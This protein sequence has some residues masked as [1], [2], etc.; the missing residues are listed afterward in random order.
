MHRLPAGLYPSREAIGWAWAALAAV[1]SPDSEALASLDLVLRETVPDCEAEGNSRVLPAGWGTPPATRRP[2]VAHPRAF[3]GTK[4]RPPKQ[5]QSAAVD[6][7]PFLSSAAGLRSVAERF[8]R[9]LDIAVAAQS[10]KLPPK[11]A[12]LLWP[13]VRHRT[14]RQ[15]SRLLSLYVA[16]GL[17]S[18]EELLHALAYS[19]AA[20]P[21]NAISWS[22]AL[23]EVPAPFRLDMAHAIIETSAFDVEAGAAGLAEVCRLAP[24]ERLRI[25]A[26]H[27]LSVVRDRGDS[28]YLLA[29]FRLAAAFDPDCRFDDAGR[30]AD[31]PESEIEAIGASLP[32]SHRGWLP[33]RLWQHCGCFPGM[34]DL[35]RNSSWPKLDRSAST[36]YLR[37]L[38]TVGP[39]EMTPRTA[40]RK[41]TALRNA[42]PRI[43]RILLT[44]DP[45]Y[46]RKAVA[47]AGDWL[48][49]WEDP[50]AIQRRL[51]A[52]LRLLE[53]LA[54]PP[55]SAAA[56][57]SWTLGGF[58]EFEN[59]GHIETFLQAPDSCLLAVERASRRDN[60]ARLIGAG[61]EAL[62]R[63]L[64]AFTADAVVRFPGKLAR[65]ARLLGGVSAPLR[66]RILRECKQ[67]ALFRLD[68]SAVTPNDLCSEV[69]AGIGGRPLTNPLPA[70]LSAWTR[71]EIELTGAKLQ[72]HCQVAAGKLV[73]TRLDLVGDSVMDFVK[74]GMPL[75]EISHSSRHA[76]RLLGSIRSNRRA[77][78]RFLRAWW[79][80]DTGY[81]ARHVETVSWY[82]RHP[83]VPR[84]IWEQ[85]IATAAEGIAIQLERD[86]FE[87]L[88][89][90]TYVGS[91]LGVGGL[92]DDSAAAALLDANKKVLYAR[93]FGGRVVARQLVAISNAGQLVCFS[94]YPSSAA[95]PV[96]NAFADHDREFAKALGLP[97]HVPATGSGDYAVDCV[98]AETW[99]DDGSWD[100][101]TGATGESP[102]PQPGTGTAS[103]PPSRTPSSN[104]RLRSRRS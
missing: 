69:M 42:L 12:C 40:Q 70:R 102:A 37:F 25:W 60:D 50:D 10:F 87:I 97:L 18:D 35:I 47:L 91:C 26:R 38:V 30:C 15:V 14:A 48:W 75:G 17:E 8:G 41:W 3:K 46:Q 1:R 76:L 65:T 81:L 54:A 55:F 6:L 28:S 56:R 22:E 93:D 4:Y 13:A 64:D 77:L 32:D 90:G 72:R 16:L 95:R 101:D 51:P 24:P 39:F 88:K 43:E 83:E 104:R 34:A 5:R 99:W 23:A 52:L 63:Q 59:A 89:L 86:P 57:G 45:G 7:R 78:R 94:V 58:L 79:A 31:F 44:I 82:R 66:E 29:G 33:M 53:R 80:G 21:L 67:H 73:L 71:G 74:R 2:T 85:G 36:D 103:Y 68:P 84:R 11:F 20:N 98:V 19:V 62:V 96:K 49:S 61:I 92:C 27:W 100:F 9:T